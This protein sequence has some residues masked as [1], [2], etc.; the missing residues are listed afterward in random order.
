MTWRDEPITQKQ[1]NLI[2]SMMEF[3]AYKL[4]F[5]DTEHAAKGE[6]SDYIDRWAKLAHEDVNSK[7]FGY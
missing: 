2:E 6:A 4:P 5:I 3:S 1:K 7:T